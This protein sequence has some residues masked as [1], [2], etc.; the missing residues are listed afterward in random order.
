[1]LKY[2]KVQKRVLFVC[3]VVSVV[4]GGLLLFFPSTMGKVI[5]FCL[6]GFVAVVGIGRIIRYASGGGSEAFG[7]RIDLYWGVLLCV[8]GALIAIFANRLLGL[9]SILIGIYIVLDGV[10]SLRNALNLKR[11]NFSRWQ[12][13]FVLAIIAIVLGGLMILRLFDSIN[14]VN[15]ILGAGLLYDGLINL[16]VAYCLNKVKPDAVVIEG[17]GIEN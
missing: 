8:C 1:M 7:G 10:A 9:L 15:M 2:L 5:C 4:L 6:A 3:A 11:L 17:N 16:W 13:V 12:V 14:I